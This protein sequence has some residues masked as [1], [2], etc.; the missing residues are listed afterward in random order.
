MFYIL[1]CFYLWIY[2]TLNK[3]SISIYVDFL[4]DK[5]SV[6]TAVLNDMV[7][8]PLCTIQYR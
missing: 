4:S 6:T 2:G 1:L 8:G 7:T 3:I 5:S